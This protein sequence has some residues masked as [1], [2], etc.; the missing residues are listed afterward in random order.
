MYAAVSGIVTVSFVRSWPAPPW[1][2]ST[3][4]MAAG[5]CWANAAEKRAKNVMYALD[6]MLFVL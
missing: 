3:V 2:A 5:V 1:L 4:T 6:N